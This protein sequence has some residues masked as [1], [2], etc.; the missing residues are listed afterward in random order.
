MHFT[1]KLKALDHQW[2]QVIFEPP[3]FFILNSFMHSLLSIVSISVQSLV[4]FMEGG[5]MLLSSEFSC[6]NLKYK[7]QLSSGERYPVPNKSTPIYITAGDGGNQ[8]GLAGRFLDPQPEYSA[9]REASYGHLTLEIQN[10][11]HAFYHWNC[12]NDGKKVATNSFVF[13]NQYW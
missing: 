7:E 12:N 3:E 9:F 6:S 1:G 10:R 5:L 4:Y 11:T 13:H 2:I 8:E